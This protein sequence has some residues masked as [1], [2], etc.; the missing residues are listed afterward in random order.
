MES[1]TAPLIRLV[2]MAALGPFSWRWPDQVETFERGWVAAA[3]VNGQ[4]VHVRHG[5]GR[6]YAYGRSRRRSVTWVEGEPTVEGVEADDFTRSESLLS[7]I[8][9]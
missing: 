7:L 8:A 4:E 3:T 6:R 1:P 2:S 9:G 5:I